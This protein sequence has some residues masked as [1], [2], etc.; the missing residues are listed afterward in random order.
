MQMVKWLLVTDFPAS[1]ILIR[2]MVG[3]VFLSEGVQ[4]FLSPDA[5][6]AGR[7][8]K[9]GIP[10][11]EFFGPFVGVFEIMC[12]SLVLLGLGTRVAA[13][14]LLVVI[15]VAII[16]TKLPMLAKDGYWKMAH[17]GRTDWAM[18]LGL[19]F[20]L[21]VGGGGWSLDS[22]LSGRTPDAGPV[23]SGG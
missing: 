10:S 8:A 21:I 2:L 18:L 4:K 14:P 5:L 11:P 3:S 7:F 12:G 19:L 20:L 9:I 1:V 15:S 13:V 22:L 16:T 23:S 6:G 17:E